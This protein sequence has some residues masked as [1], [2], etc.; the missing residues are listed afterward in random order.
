MNNL[1]YASTPAVL[2]YLKAA[3]DMGIQPDKALDAA[4]LGTDVL[5]NQVKRIT[6]D[7]FQRL[8]RYLIDSLDDT[9]FGLKSSKYVQPGSYSVLGY[10]VMNCKTLTEALRRTPTYEALVGDMGTTEFS[11]LEDGFT[12]MR[13]NCQYTDPVVRHHMIDNVLGSWV[14]FARFLVDKPEG[15][16]KQV[17]LERNRPQE[18]DLKFYESIF[19]CP[20]RFS[21]PYNCLVLDDHL[22]GLPIRQPD[23]QLLKTLEGHAE[24][25][26][27]DISRNQPLPMQTRNVIKGLLL[28]GIPRKEMVAKRLGLTERTLQRKLQQFD[29]SYQQILDDLRKEQAIDLLLQ[30]ELPIQEIAHRLGFSEPRSFHRSFKSWVGMTPGEYRANHMK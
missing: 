15:R 24:I 22:L 19:R 5:E 16:P 30:S 23:S 18:S 6:G 28:E 29:T 2:Q 12:Q 8:L 14:N 25:L 11:I 10:M 1:G 27:A 4:G 17:W 26:M 3:A 21:A 7:A 9:C 20:I 13:W